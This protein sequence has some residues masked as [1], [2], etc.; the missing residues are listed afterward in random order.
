MEKLA[1]IAFDDGFRN[2]RGKR[3]NKSV[4]EFILKNPVYCGDFRWNN[5]LYHGTHEKIVTRELFD[6]AQAQLNGTN[7][8]KLVKGFAYSGLLT[9]AK[10]GFSITAEIKKG[11]YVYY[12][13]TGRGGPCGNTYV[14]EEELTKQFAE[15]VK[16]IHIDDEILEAVKKAL[17]E[18]HEDERMYHA[19]KVTALT[20]QKERL[21]NRI[22]QIYIDKLDKKISSEKY[23]TM[24]FE[25]NEELGK[26]QREIAKHEN[27]DANYLS[28]GV[29]ILELCNRA[30]GLYLKQEPREGAKILHTILSNC[31]MDGV[32]LIPEM[33]KPF[34]FI[35]K[36][37]SRL[38]WLRSYQTKRTIS[39]A[40]VRVPVFLQRVRQQLVI[41][42]GQPPYGIKTDERI[43]RKIIRQAKPKVRRPSPIE[44]ALTYAKVL[45][46]PSVVSKSQVAQRFGVSRARV[47][48]VLNLLDLDAAILDQLTSIEDVEEHNFFT[49][50]RLRSLAVMN[51]AEQMAEFNRLR[52]ESR[53]ETRLIQAV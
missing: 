37:L 48:Q 9:C 34:S 10:C 30:Y 27:A 11:R 6:A 43:T 14:R 4:I 28:Q 24:T 22:H 39:V 31:K 3:V 42:P 17:L 1:E 21:E 53:R 47:S 19:Q 2:K 15:I 13:C 45:Q 26:M 7:R 5:R 36:G 23:E 44:Q 8:P 16:Q 52:Q 20:V 33:R 49:E 18:S 40:R 32:T 38:E 25:W 29:H 50:H 41:M 51:E 12:H 46:E 35:A